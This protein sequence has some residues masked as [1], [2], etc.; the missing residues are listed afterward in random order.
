MDPNGTDEKFSLGS[1]AV[2]PRGNRVVR[3]RRSYR[4]TRREMDVL[5]FLAG[6]AGRVATRAEIIEAVWHDVIVSDDAL[7]LAV[8]RL[9]KALGD[10]P[11]SPELIETVPTRGYRLMQAPGP[12]NP[13]IGT[14]AERTVAGQARPSLTRYRVGIAVLTVVVLLVSA[15]FL[16]VRF[17]Y[18]EVQR[19]EAC[20]A[21]GP[22]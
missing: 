16:A 10:D 18:E 2:E 13:E 8:S 15:L 14:A 4:V 11:R 17:R 22:C 5:V 3:G 1:V 21:G 7:T 6:R 9:R 20:D 19:V 12:G